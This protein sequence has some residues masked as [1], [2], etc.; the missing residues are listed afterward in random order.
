MIGSFESNQERGREAVQKC[1]VPMGGLASDKRSFHV[2]DIDAVVVVTEVV[3]IA[4]V[5][6]AHLLTQCRAGMF[7]GMIPCKTGL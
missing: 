7:P 3:A 5:P 1:L 6:G 2:L 4:E